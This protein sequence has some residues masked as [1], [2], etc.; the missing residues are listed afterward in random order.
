VAGLIV[1]G[2]GQPAPARL[3]QQAHRRVVA[4]V[5]T[6]V[7]VARLHGDVGDEIEARGQV[8]RVATHGPAC[9]A[10]LVADQS[11]DN[12]RRACPANGVFTTNFI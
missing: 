3:V 11:V 7:D 12:N 9:A 5:P 6:V 10:R 2:G 4:E 8:K 1:P